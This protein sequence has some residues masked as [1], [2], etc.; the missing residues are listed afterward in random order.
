MLSQDFILIWEQGKPGWKSTM[1]QIPS[2]YC[3]EWGAQIHNIL[4]FFNKNIVL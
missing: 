2:L 4:Y 1:F 3:A